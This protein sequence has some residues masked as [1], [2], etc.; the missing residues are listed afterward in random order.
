MALYQEDFP[1]G[2]TVRIGSR[3]QLLTFQRTWKYHHKLTTEQLQYASEIAKVKTLTFYHGGDPL[4]E[5]QGIPGIWHEQC[6][7][8]FDNSPPSE[9]LADNE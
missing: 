6:L 9:K 3:H 8:S 1:I 7:S 4:Y 2:T 5:L